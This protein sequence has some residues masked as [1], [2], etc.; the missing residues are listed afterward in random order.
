MGL[1]Q[2][3]FGTAFSFVLVFVGKSM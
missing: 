2:T 3:K 1:P